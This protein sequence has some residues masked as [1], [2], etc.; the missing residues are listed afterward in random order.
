MRFG[1]AR[2][3]R[4]GEGAAALPLCAMTGATQFLLIILVAT[5]EV[6]GRHGLW[7]KMPS[8]PAGLY[9]IREFQ[10]E[11]P[12]GETGGKPLGS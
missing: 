4:P 12:H 11:S 6:A 3:A 2:D 10:P 8:L 7:P 9:R 5:E 1:R